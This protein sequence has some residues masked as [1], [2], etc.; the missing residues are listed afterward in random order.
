M[1]MPS[2]TSTSSAHAVNCPEKLDATAGDPVTHSTESGRNT[3]RCPT[4]ACAV[5][6]ARSCRSAAGLAGAR[7]I[8]VQPLAE[9]AAY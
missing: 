4:A 9:S 1:H 5:S 7:R 6:V 3:Q 8:L 2:A